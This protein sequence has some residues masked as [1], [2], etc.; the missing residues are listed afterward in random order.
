MPYNY[1]VVLPLLGKIRFILP[2]FYCH[3]MW[4]FH[5]F[6]WKIDTILFLCLLSTT[7][8]I[9]FF[10]QNCVAYKLQYLWVLRKL[11]VM[12]VIIMMQFNN[13]NKFTR[14]NQQIKVKWNIILIRVVCFLPNKV[15]CVLL[16]VLSVIVSCRRLDQSPQVQADPEMAPVLWELPKDYASLLYWGWWSFVLELCSC[17]AYGL[18][19]RLFLLFAPTV[20]E[21]SSENHGSTEPAGW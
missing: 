19:S 17:Q 3:R 7:F 11:L 5:S 12:V 9:Y 2:P 13:W 21:E 8:F 6:L 16:I 1:P 4:C 15:I 10:S 20:S 18:C 14:E